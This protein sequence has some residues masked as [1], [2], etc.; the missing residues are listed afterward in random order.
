MTPK[1]TTITLA[2]RKR[3]VRVEIGM[4]A[5]IEAATDKGVIELLRALNEGRAKLADIATVLQVV[6]AGNG[7]TYDD[8]EMFAMIE[9]TGIIKSMTAAATVIAGLFKGSVKTSGKSKAAKVANASQPA[10]S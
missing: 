5:Q 6:L 9:E 3:T 10:T 2:G 1:T 8:D 4:A 7:D